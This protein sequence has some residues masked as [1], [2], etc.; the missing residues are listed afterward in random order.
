VHH[1]TITQFS[2]GSKTSEHDLDEIRMIMNEALTGGQSAIVQLNEKVQEI[3]EGYVNIC[4]F[5]GQTT[6]YKTLHRKLKIV[7][8]EPP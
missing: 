3:I 8:H 4:L 1:E 2:K 7:H 5:K 6:I